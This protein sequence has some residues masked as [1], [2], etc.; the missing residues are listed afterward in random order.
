MSE[1]FN[2]KSFLNLN[3]YDSMQNLVDHVIEIDQDDDLYNQI[4][5]EPLFNKVPNKE[6]LEELKSKIK[7]L[8][9]I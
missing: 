9:K 7:N 5:K 2:T 3:D 4:I 8:I 1:D 6:N